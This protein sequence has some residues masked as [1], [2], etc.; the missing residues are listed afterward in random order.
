MHKSIVTQKEFNMETK[1]KESCIFQ[2]REYVADSEICQGEDCKVCVD[3]RL[4]DWRE[5][6][7]P[8]MIEE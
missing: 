7:C 5:L 3:G 4:T 1:G 8:H 6:C 2:G